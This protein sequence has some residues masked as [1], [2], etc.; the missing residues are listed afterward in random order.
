M[1][2]S[3]LKFKTQ[4]EVI[5]YTKERMKKVDGIKVVELKIGEFAVS[6]EKSN[7]RIHSSIQMNKDGFAPV[8]LFFSHLT[9]RFNP[10]TTSVKSIPERLFIGDFDE[11]ELEQIWAAMN[12]I[13]S[14]WGH[15]SKKKRKEP[16]FII[17]LNESD[18]MWKNAREKMEEMVQRITKGTVLEKVAEGKNKVE[19]YKQ[20]DFGGNHGR[21]A[22]EVINAVFG[23]YVMPK[24]TAATFFELNLEFVQELEKVREVY[25][26]IIIK[27]LSA[28]REK[29]ST[30]HILNDYLNVRGKLMHVEVYTKE[31]A[32]ELVA[33]K[34][35]V[36]VKENVSWEWSLVDTIKLGT[37]QEFFTQLELGERHNHLFTHTVKK[38]N[39]EMLLQDVIDVDYEC[40]V[41]E[42]FEKLVSLTELPIEAE[43][44]SAQFLR[45]LEAG[46]EKVVLSD[47]GKFVLY[48]F[49]INATNWYMMTDLYKQELTFYV[50]ER[51]KAKEMLLERL[52][53]FVESGQ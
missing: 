23:I 19:M 36:K 45:L 42:Q 33:E 47:V 53:K 44:I 27:D 39:F 35:Q 37:L 43:R 21:Y 31:F 52:K 7:L 26:E 51:E 15:M 41:D 50:G 14:H 1:K 20:Y 24:S 48:E 12:E 49:V 32:F 10:F 6:L 18:L 4:E 38:D 30:G 22:K 3:E 34:K 25:P 9:P 16:F 2:T 29:F 8:V 28:S 40:E 17:R 5:E 46:R 11:E 13:I